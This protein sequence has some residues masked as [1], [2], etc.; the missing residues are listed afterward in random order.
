MFCR[1]SYNCSIG[2]LIPLWE[3]ETKLQCSSLISNRN[4]TAAVL[5][6]WYLWPHVSSCFG[7]KAPYSRPLCSVWTT[8]DSGA[9]GNSSEFYGLKVLM[10][11]EDLDSS[12]SW[13]AVCSCVSGGERARAQAQL[14]CVFIEADYSE[15]E[16]EP[17]ITLL[18]ISMHKN[19]DHLTVQPT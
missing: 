5:C 12:L 8:H 7:T 10:S 18:Y 9:E 6:S 2:G 13:V 1:I 16:Q 17:L 3:C 19:N 11:G 4:N 15:V 14:P